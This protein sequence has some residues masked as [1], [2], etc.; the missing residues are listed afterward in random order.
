ME[1]SFVILTKKEVKHANENDYS[2]HGICIEL[3]KSKLNS[4]FLTKFF[5]SHS[6]ELKYHGADDINKS[7]LV[8]HR[9]IGVVSSTKM[10]FT[11]KVEY[12]L[13]SI[14]QKLLSLL[15]IQRNT[16]EQDN[17]GTDACFTRAALLLPCRSIASALQFN[18]LNFFTSITIVEPTFKELVFV[19]KLTEE[20]SQVVDF[21][22]SMHSLPPDLNSP[23]IHL[24]S[25]KNV[26][27]ADMEVGS[28]FVIPR[29]FS[30]LV[31]IFSYNNT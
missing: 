31:L 1:A 5:N 16:H 20:P 22:D 29:T 21:R 15:G 14:K 19:Y 23:R 4:G 2:L 28:F 11:E 12:V 7:F 18:W 17:Y 6:L 9:G 25:F 24:K 13:S 30:T 26:P 27:I 8:Y 10:F 3:D